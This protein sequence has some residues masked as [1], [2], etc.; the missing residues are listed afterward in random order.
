MITFI[1][2]YISISFI[3]FIKIKD[4]IF[5]RIDNITCGI[6]YP[7]FLKKIV[8]GTFM[9][10]M[11]LELPI[12]TLIVLL[13]SMI[14][15]IKIFLRTKRRHSLTKNSYNMRTR[16]TIILNLLKFISIIIMSSYCLWND[17]L[18]DHIG[19][20]PCILAILFMFTRRSWI[21]R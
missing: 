9:L 10:V 8:V 18:L 13:Y 4:T 20:I 12:F 2:I 17:F 21:N 15:K 14:L 19:G 5:E 1:F 6:P 7:E 11:I 16:R 3:I